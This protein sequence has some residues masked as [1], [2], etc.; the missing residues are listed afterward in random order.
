[1]R[2]LFE[3]QVA[4]RIKHPNIVDISDYGMIPGGTAY[5]VMEYLTG[6]TLAARI[7][8]AGR[9]EPQLALEIAQQI[10]LGLQAAHASKVIHRDLKSENIFLCTGPD[11]GV[12][13]KILD[14]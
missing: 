14:F 11:G 2:F 8:R 4:S 6:E 1:K 13:V 9:L 5:Y 7:D 10:L 12:Q 3:A